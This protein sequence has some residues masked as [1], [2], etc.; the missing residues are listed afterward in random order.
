MTWLILINCKKSTILHY[1]ILNSC[2]KSFIL[3]PL[4]FFE[5][6]IICRNDKC[7]RIKSI[8]GLELGR[9]QPYSQ[10]FDSAKMPGC[11]KCTMIHYWGLNSYLNS[12]I[13]LDPRFFGENVICLNDKFNSIK[14]IKGLHLGRLLHKSQIFDSAKIVLLLKSTSLCYFS[15]ITC[16]KSFIVQAPGLFYRKS[17]IVKTSNVTE[18]KAPN[19]Y[20]WESITYTRKY[21]TWLKLFY[22]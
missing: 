3:Q 2:L 17:N 19:G 6:N 9:L 21:L 10:I 12:L 18:L 14:R 15:L 5:E 22:C 1:C 20:T 11:D 7:Y 16:L 8:E 4:G 13:V